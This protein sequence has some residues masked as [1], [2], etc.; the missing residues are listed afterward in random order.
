MPL[1]ANW[2][3]ICPEI[4]LRSTRA[5][6]DAQREQIEMDRVMAAE[7]EDQHNNEIALRGEVESDQGESDGTQYDAVWKAI[8]IT[9][10][11]IH[12]PPYSIANFHLHCHHLHCNFHLHCH[13]HHLQSPLHLQHHSRPPNV[14]Q[15][16]AITITAFIPST[17]TCHCT[18]TCT[19]K[20][21]ATS[22]TCLLMQEPLQRHFTWT[23]EC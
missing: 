23:N 7:Y 12:V 9:I 19:C 20:A 11:I 2:E 21:I 13:L 15:S 5:Q 4:R 18:C 8:S 10:S 6:L 1:G 3:T 16:P 14:L 22:S 17:T